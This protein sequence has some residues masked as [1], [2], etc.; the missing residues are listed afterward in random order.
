MTSAPVADVGSFMGIA[1]SAKGLQ[2]GND[3]PEYFRNVLSRQT[4]RETP[5]VSVSGSVAGT[6]SRIRGKTVNQEKVAK[7]E[8]GNALREKE[9][10]PGEQIDR[11]VEDAAMQML[12]NVAQELDMTVAEA[13]QLLEELHLEPEDLLNPDNIPVFVLAAAGSTDKMELLTDQQLYDSVKNLT[14]ELEKLENT[15]MQETG[16]TQ[17]ELEE[18]LRKL[19]D[20]KETGNTENRNMDAE[21]VRNASH[22]E[23]QSENGIRTDGEAKGKEPEITVVR[24]TAS[25]GKKDGSP[26]Q[27]SGNQFFRTTVENAMAVKPEGFTVG[28]LTEGFTGKIMN[29]IMD[30]MNMDLQP[31]TTE[32][33]MQ[34]HPENLGKVNVHISAREGVITAQFTAQNETVKAVLESQMIQLKENFTQQGIRVEAVEVTVEN[35]GFDRNMD[36]EGHSGGEEQEGRKS[37]PRKLRV[38]LLDGLEAGEL[39]EEEKMAVRMMKDSGNTV[40]YTA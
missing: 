13:E 35:Q 16:L 12:V 40:D 2:S 6:R 34:L 11:A 23:Q 21:T 5:E 4:G 32:L 26:E 20:G 18:V 22:K 10:I 33:E 3:S 8:R 25:E 14:G 38:D 1:A 17:N 30:Y 31:D 28:T 9:E 29:Q 37:R 36:Q 39:S 27:N 24:H 15:V 19:K 7:P